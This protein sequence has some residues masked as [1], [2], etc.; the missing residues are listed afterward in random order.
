MTGAASIAPQPVVQRRWVLQA[1]A[2]LVVLLALFLLWSF[3]GALIDDAF[4]TLRYADTLRD[5]GHWGFYPDAVTNTATAPLNVM[6]TALVGLVVRDLPTTAW[7]LAALELLALGLVWVSLGRHLMGK[8]VLGVVAAG[9]VVANPLLLSSLG[10]EGVLYVTLTGV[11]LALFTRERWAALGGILGLLTLTRPDGVLLALVMAAFT[12]ARCRSVRPVLVA[13]A[14]FTAVVL[15]WLL[16]SWVVV[17]GLVPDTLF[18][19]VS[20]RRWGPWTFLDGPVFYARLFPLAWALTWLPVLPAVLAFRVPQPEVRRLAAVLVAFALAYYLAYVTL[21]VPPY[22]W[23]YGPVVGA[24]LLVSALG[25]TASLRDRALLVPAVAAVLT[26]VLFAPPGRRAGE[27][28]IHTNWASPA[29]YRAM[30]RAL[31]AAVP[32]GQPVGLEGEV[33]ALGFYAARRLHNGFST[34][35][36]RAFIR[37]ELE[38]R[39]GLLR[40]FG[41]LNFRFYEPLPSAPPPAWALLGTPGPMRR[42]AA[43]VAGSLPLPPGAV[44]ARWRIESRPFAPGAYTLYG[45]PI[46]RP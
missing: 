36:R 26:V 29:Q 1:G 38:V 37:E 43:P 17:G 8:P 23:Y 30:A 4:I 18:I 28:P 11:A 9:L 22:H 44:R 3:G 25:L 31:D 35:E 16:Y 2:A 32:P 40:A 45:P 41:R 6:L 46:T 13:L 14:A 42:V 12:V 39:G 20:Q 7:V 21:G 5:A 15:P 27:V 19:K 10:L 33:G 24:G 34:P